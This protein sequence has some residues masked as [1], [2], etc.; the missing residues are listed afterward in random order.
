MADWPWLVLLT[1]YGTCVGSFLNVVIYRLPAGLSIVRP[2]SRCPRCGHGLAIYDNIPVLGWLWLRGRCRYCQTPISIQYPLIEA[3]CAVLFVGMYWVDYRSGWQPGFMAGGPSGTWPA[4]VVQLALL[5]V[6]VASTG[7]D[8]RYYIIPLE[9]TH[10]MTALALLVLP[11]STVWLPEIELIFSNSNMTVMV[12]P[13]GVAA[14]FGALAGLMLAW[15]LLWK[16][17]LPRSFDEEMIESMDPSSVNGEVKSS[18]IDE[19]DPT[20]RQG[21]LASLLMIL[22]LIAAVVGVAWWNGFGEPIQSA[23]TWRA[24]VE[25][26]SGERSLLVHTLIG[27]MLGYLIVGLMYGSMR[28]PDEAEDILGEYPNP[29]WEVL[30]ESLFLSLPIVGAVCGYWTVRYLNSEVGLSL[31]HGPVWSV[32]G[33]VLMGY[34][35]GGG[36]IWGVRV[37]GTLAFGREAMGLGDVH[38]LAAIGAV[39]GPRHA[40]LIFFLAPF[41]GLASALGMMV[42]SRVKQV[43]GRVIPY[44]PYLAAAAVAVMA[45]RGPIERVFVIFFS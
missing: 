32:L 15:V 27:A 41:F 18:Q 13:N 45:L 12:P 35:V 11:L 22:P 8:A 23:D 37:L 33:A 25:N 4:L 1:I 38:L 40:V 16:K 30:K 21:L 39:V 10:L 42:M 28:Q 24:W 3:L 2:A 31:G 36:I 19:T 9:A 34:L 29:R 14:A 26:S 5:A 7:I 17:V 6:L 44:G 20:D 43:T